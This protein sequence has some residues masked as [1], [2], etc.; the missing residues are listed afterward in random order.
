MHA[1]ERSASGPCQRLGPLRHVHK[2]FLGKKSH[3][4]ITILTVKNEC[5]LVYGRVLQHA[6]T[7]HSVEWGSGDSKHLNESIG[8]K[9]GLRRPRE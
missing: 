4:R 5:N 6:K 8:N 2:H 1:I 3:L 7:F 9:T